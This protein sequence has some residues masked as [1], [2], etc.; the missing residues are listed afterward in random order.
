MDIELISN[1]YAQLEKLFLGDA[2]QAYQAVK[3]AQSEVLA[4]FSI[5]LFSGCTLYEL[6]RYE[7]KKKLIE[8][9]ELS[10]GR[11]QKQTSSQ[12]TSQSTVVAMPTQ[13]RS[14]TSSMGSARTMP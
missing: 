3:A 8:A 5:D 12:K 6:H 11:P 10:Q 14:L 13:T 9:H 4:S 7:P 2:S 1:D